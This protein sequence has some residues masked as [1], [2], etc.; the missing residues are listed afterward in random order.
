MNTRRHYIAIPLTLNEWVSRITPGVMDP[1]TKVFGDI[2]EGGKRLTI[3]PLGDNEVGRRIG[4]C[5]DI[6]FCEAGQKERTDCLF[7]FKVEDAKK[8]L[9][10]TTP[11]KY[12][13]E[14]FLRTQRSP[15]DYLDPI[16]E[17]F[18]SYVTQG[19][20]ETGLMG[21]SAAQSVLYGKP[22]ERLLEIVRSAPA[23]LRHKWRPR[24]RETDDLSVEEFLKSLRI[25]WFKYRLENLASLTPR[26][27][28]LIEGGTKPKEMGK[29]ERNALLTALLNFNL[30][31]G[32]SKA[33]SGNPGLVHNF[34]DDLS[35]LAS[36]DFLHSSVWGSM[37]SGLDTQ[38]LKRELHSVAD[39]LLAIPSEN[40]QVWAA[41]LFENLLV[42][43]SRGQD[44]ALHEV[45]E[46]GKDQSRPLEFLARWA[47][48]QEFPAEGTGP[49]LSAGSDDK[50]PPSEQP[51]IPTAGQEVSAV[52]LEPKQIPPELG[53]PEKVS[54]LR[55]AVFDQWVHGLRIPELPDLDRIKAQIVERLSRVTADIALLKPG[56]AFGQI[57]L[58]LRQLQS[59]LSTWVPQL[60][61]PAIL[62]A[63]YDE[64]GKA[65]DRAYS[66]VGQELDE[67]LANQRVRPRDLAEA[68]D[69]V[70]THIDVLK[71]LP[72]WILDLEAND[73]AENARVPQEQNLL[74]RLIIPGLRERLTLILDV[75]VEVGG[76][77][78]DL[79]CWVPPLPSAAAR[80]N[81]NDEVA[82]YVRSKLTQTSNFLQSVPKDLRTWMRSTLEPSQIQ[83]HLNKY[84]EFYQKVKDRISPESLKQ[85]LEHVHSLSVEMESVELSLF[86]R[87]IEFFEENMGDATEASFKS[88]QAWVNKNRSRFKD[89]QTED[90]QLLT[91]EHNWTDR[92]QKAPLIFF[93]H[94]D[95]R[96]AYGFVT[97][98]LV[99]E[100]NQPKS[101]S[102]KLETHVKT[103]QREAWPR[104][105][106]NP[107]PDILRI[108]HHEWRE[109]A[110]E[111]NYIY[112]LRLEIPISLS[113]KTGRRF[114]IELN[115]LDEEKATIAGKPKTLSWDSIEST[116]GP[117]KLNW[118]ENTDPGVVTKHPIGPQQKSSVILNR[119]ALGGSFAVVAPRRFGKTTLVEYI[120]KEARQMGFVVPKPVGCTSYPGSGE[121][122]YPRVWHEVS[123]ELQQTLGASL[124][125]LQGSLPEVDSFDFVRRAAARDG[126][127]GILILVDEAQLFFPRKDSGQL[128]DLLKDRLERHWSRKDDPHMV[129]V[130]LG[131]IGLPSFQ[132]RAGANLCGLVNPLVAN[133]MSEQ[134]LNKLILH[135][136]SGSLSTTREA[137][138]RLAK[139]AGNL[140]VLK[141]MVAG[142]V[143]SL[144][145]ERRVWA[146]YDDIVKVENDLKDSLREGRNASVAAYVKDAL[147]DAESINSWIPNRSFGVALA[148]ALA[149]SQGARGTSRIY[150]RAKEILNQWCDTAGVD[151]TKRYL[152][153]DRCL[154][155]HLKTLTDRGVLRDREFASV[156][157][158]AWLLG[159]LKTE[160]PEENVWKVILFKGALV[161]LRI[162][163]AQREG[164]GG[165][166]AIWSYT[167]GNVKYAL[168]KTDLRTEE[169]RNRFL[170]SMKTLEIL[171]PCIERGDPGS[172]YI[173]RL[174]QAGLADEEGIQAVQIYHWIDGFDLGKRK[175]MVRPHFLVDTGARLASAVRFLHQNDILHRDIRPSNV[176]FQEEGFKPVLIDFGFAR[177]LSDSPKTLFDSEYSA[178]EVRRSNPKWTKAADIYSLAATLKVLIQPSVDHKRLSE[179]LSDCLEEQPEDRPTAEELVELFEILSRE[180]HIEDSRSEVW[181]R[182]EELTRP[183]DDKEWFLRILDKFRPNMQAVR[184]GFLEDSFDR[185]KEISDIL[186]QLLE[187]YSDGKVAKLKLSLVKDR[188]EH[189]GDRLATE[190][191]R[192]LHKA[193]NYLSHG[194]NKKAQIMQEF[195]NPSPVQMRAWAIEGAEKIASCVGLRTLPDLV[196]YIYY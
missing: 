121:L 35:D 109:N 114:E 30:L 78:A 15:G 92:G 89:G 1:A 38:E 140:F 174:H 178:P 194:E 90:S 98:P 145:A 93:P 32:F 188:N 158:E 48:R 33:N 12:E 122:D 116:T 173:F 189:T 94:P 60:P 20:L 193:R 142:L 170:E 87:A 156:F 131:F 143:E 4:L 17:L 71:K 123:N 165:Q 112:T 52:V 74:Q 113:R 67:I 167:E 73:S 146:N 149:R 169:E 110:S 47:M 184:M 118:P 10:Q 139:S 21:S 166:A 57:A 134:E 44:S 72:S 14:F 8:R 82:E 22:S 117:L 187:S 31:N 176:V 160:L 138:T 95:Q 159:Y 59:D 80:E 39:A 180:L 152:F 162:P 25:P 163:P 51:S 84:I 76:E 53:T 164:E 65:Y 177:R 144:E 97:V 23:P 153:D 151:P 157:M 127:R 64:G 13:A 190:A 56:P 19:Q 108:Y 195:G 181:N 79:L 54:S 18:S 103:G 185:C 11:V 136:T 88:L 62:D 2:T 5:G 100:T 171:K 172:E 68:A 46:N 104:E 115:L 27:E 9:P 191:I 120:S 168:R 41:A 179:V 101:L 37:L 6:Y 192:F 119:V 26:Q 77:N 196:N 182:I 29:K 132:E 133:Q 175:G 24:R 49:V 161:R 45:V 137:R 55:G 148:F 83:H 91:I 105:W 75:L 107:K 111:G 66:V 34:L 150:D 183:D 96:Q 125:R 129:P 141:T 63:D 124:G 155:E 69:L 50:V 36:S 3:V 61:D 85:T 102:V 28:A 7:V 40:E 106:E 42:V 147:N 43:A 81:E 186:N 154:S 16:E 86:E 58:H 126:K 135:V 70:A 128:G 99:I 130:I